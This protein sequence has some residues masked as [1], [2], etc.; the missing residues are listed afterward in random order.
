MHLDPAVR[1]TAQELFGV[2]NKIHL[3]EPLEV[4]D[5]HNFMSKSYIIMTDSGGI[6]EEASSL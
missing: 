6:Q 3:I 2:D 5:F 4:L 1:K